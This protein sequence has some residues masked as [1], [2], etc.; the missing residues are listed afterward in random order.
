[1]TA[2]AG[3]VVEVDVGGVVVLG[4]QAAS[5][6]AAQAT[7]V[8]AIASL[9]SLRPIVMIAPDLLDSNCAIDKLDG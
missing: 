1:L 4:E 7:T 8:P 5:T 3:V 6:S 2:W 9:L